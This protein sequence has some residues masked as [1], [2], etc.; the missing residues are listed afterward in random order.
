MDEIPT[1]VDRCPKCASVPIQRVAGGKRCGQCAHQWD[2]PQIEI[3]DP[4]VAAKDY[5]AAMEKWRADQE[6]ADRLADEYELAE[7]M[8]EDCEK[9]G[10]AER[11]AHFAENFRRSAR[12]RKRAEEQMGG[13]GSTYPL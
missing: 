1:Q 6:K 5:V 13:F 4:E 10:N 11:D 12:A 9:T 2:Q 8:A 3:A 7:A